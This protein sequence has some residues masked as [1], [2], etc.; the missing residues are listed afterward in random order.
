[1]TAEHE[2]KIG[3]IFS[4]V[5]KLEVSVSDIKGGMN[6]SDYKHTEAKM[7]MD[8]AQLES[9][10]MQVQLDTFK[11]S[12]EADKNKVKGAAFIMTTI[13]AAFTTFFTYLFVKN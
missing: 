6:L 10:L 9:E 3:K 4:I 13:W 5:S 7:K 11:A 2:D 12:Y 8:R 1:M